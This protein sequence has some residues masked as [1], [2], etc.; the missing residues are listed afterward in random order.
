[1]S[2]NENVENKKTE[3]KSLKK[4]FLLFL[5][6]SPVQSVFGIVLLVYLARIFI[7][8]QDEFAIKFQAL[9]VAFFWVL[10]VVAK[11]IIKLILFIALLLVGAYG[12]YNYNNHDKI[13]CEDS[14]GYWNAKEE[15]CEEK[16]G[17]WQWIKGKLK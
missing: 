12:Y 15:I 17:I 10:W 5:L 11:S 9:G 3:E 4:R 7:F 2:E 6:H 1:M 16:T 8:G 13:S 14:G